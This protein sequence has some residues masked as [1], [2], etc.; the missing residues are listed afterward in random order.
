MDNHMH[1]LPCDKERQLKE[2]LNKC[3]VDLKKITEIKE[4]LESNVTEIV[5]YF[6]RLYDEADIARL[7]VVKKLKE[8]QEK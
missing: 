1:G 5:Q 8:I 4:K 6:K 2:E 3:K 7:V